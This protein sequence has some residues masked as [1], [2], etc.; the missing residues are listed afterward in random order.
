MSISSYHARARI[1]VGAESVHRRHRPQAAD[2]DREEPA[3]PQD[4]EVLAMEL[5]DAAFV[6]PGVLHVGDGVGRAFRGLG[7]RR[8][9]GRRLERAGHL[10]GAPRLIPVGPLKSSAFSSA[11]WRR[12]PGSLLG[13]VAAGRQDDEAK[14]T[15]DEK[16]QGGHGGPPL[17]FRSPALNAARPP[18]GLSAR[19]SIMTRM[20]KR[21][22]LE[23]GVAATAGVAAA[24][25]GILPVSAQGKFP[26]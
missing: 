25:L 7:R 26:Q 10:P 12:L 1:D 3:A 4:H 9:S 20:K 11:R 2:L 23:L 8:G 14:E 21:T 22:F 19:A 13:A 16:A 17:L 15:Q 24:G 18:K 5:D 6:D